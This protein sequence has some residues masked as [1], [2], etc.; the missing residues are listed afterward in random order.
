MNTLKC[1]NQRDLHTRHKHYT[2]LIQSSSMCACTARSHT[3]TDPTQKGLW[4]D[5]VVQRTAND[6]LTIWG[7]CRRCSEPLRDRERLKSNIIELA[8]CAECSMNIRYD[9][10]ILIYYSMY[11]CE[12]VSLSVDQSCLFYMLQTPI[13]DSDYTHSKHSLRV[14]L[15][16]L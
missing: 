16:V 9:I 13:C 15:A 6:Y 1:A 4:V 12:S 8:Q 14:S 11:I 7:Q 3:Y 5:D 2:T 10:H